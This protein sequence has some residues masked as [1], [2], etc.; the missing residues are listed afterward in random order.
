MKN[1]ELDFNRYEQLAR[2]VAAD[3]M[4]LLRNENRALPLV[5]GTKVA[6]FGRMQNHY[7]RSGTG[8]GGMVNAPINVTIAEAFEQEKNITTD[9]ELRALYAEWEK[10]NPYQLNKGWGAEYW[11][12]EEM[13]LTK[14]LAEKYAAKNDVAVVI[15]ARTAGE[16]RDNSGEEGSFALRASEEQ[17]LEVVCAAFLRVIVILNIGNVIDMK[18]I[19]QYKPQ[20][21][22]LGWQGGMMGAYATLDILTGRVNPS[23]C[24]A[25]SVAL[26]V[27]DYPSDKDFGD[28]QRDIY[29]EDIYVGYRY[30]ETF[31]KDR[32]IYPFG[33]GLSYTEF[34]IK[35][36]ALS[37]DGQKAVVK[38]TVTNTGDMAG[39]K[40][41][42]AYVEA[43]QGKLGKPARVLAGFKKTEILAAGA[44]ETIEIEI[45]NKAM[46]SFD[47]TGAICS[48]FVME[49]GEYKLYVGANVRDAKEAGAFVLDEDVIVEKLASAMK[50]AVAYER[51]K[52]MVVEGQKKVACN[53]DE[54]KMQEN[55]CAKSSTAICADSETNRY[56]IAWEKTPLRA[57]EL[58]R[59]T[60]KEIPYEPQKVRNFG[61]VARGTVTMEEFL[62]GVPN[63]DLCSIARGEG[64]R[65][66][67]VTPGTASAFGGVNEHLK[68]LGVPCGCC[69]DGPSGMRL[70]CGQKALSLPNG[71]MIACTFDPQLV[72][73]L[74]TM[75]GIEM[76]KNKVDVLLGPGMN[77][78][79]HPYNGRNFEY[80]SEDP[81]L[82]GKMAAAQIRALH[83]VGVD[84]TLKHFCGNN[85]E[86][87][88]HSLDSVISE[89]ALR[90]IYLKGFE[91]A[92]KES[93]AHF[94]MTTYG[95][96]NGMWTSNEYELTQVI[97]REQWGFDGMVMTDWWAAI[98]DTGR[99]D[100][101]GIPGN[102]TNFTRMI[103]A[104]NDVYMCCPHSETNEHG[105]NLAE[106]LGNGTLTRAELAECAGHVLSTLLHLPTMERALGEE[107]KVTVTAQA[108]Y[109]DE[110]K[111]ET[112]AT[113]EIGEDECT[114]SLEGVQ[115]A[116]GDSY[117]FGLNIK[118]PGGY[119]FELETQSGS[120]LSIPLPATV[121]IG[122]EPIENITFW[123]VNG[124]IMTRTMKIVIDSETA[125]WR[126]FF[127][128]DGLQVRKMTFR[129]VTDVETARK[130]GEYR[131]AVM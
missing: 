43:P 44:S 116:R 1:W 11:S 94:V 98:N 7:Y 8:S 14:E 42:Q 38:V 48:G 58:E 68:E 124:E 79:R 83:S 15:I 6:L 100:A 32:I 26:E 21:V 51:M 23:G 131:E 72:E 60:A 99:E 20:A 109:W 123:G 67:K 55:G 54:G 66:E 3:G 19:E 114:F 90:E 107:Q 13:P 4:V 101:A 76:R 110:S 78:H 128:H 33:F 64:M 115:S 70:D 41:V 87:R 117:A 16:D 82:T 86:T 125:V 127:S 73:E 61:E 36:D 10:E 120:A 5:E 22:L 39:A 59:K 30:F 106:N 85:Q 113:Y 34:D 111:I 105:D 91:I 2:R 129:Y 62:A 27:T 50:P 74:Y 63:E 40:V 52:P 93:D 46:A 56:A 89:R 57:G 103:K 95:R 37:Y 84:G 65:S 130:S 112:A 96:V 45:D 71:T 122:G 126:L 25:D 97:L 49:Q 28:L 31:A 75:T 29:R 47:D 17:M 102:K 12:Q 18:F 92:V 81:L 80:F 9:A 24:L 69:D 77:I 118:K 104:R 35:N 88:R 53:T 121:L 108:D 119:E